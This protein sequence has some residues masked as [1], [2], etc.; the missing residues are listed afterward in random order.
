MFG[1]YRRGDANDP[2]TY[3]ASV[4]AV[5]SGYPPETIKYVT[6]PRTGMASNP[7]RDPKTGQ[8]W[9]GLPDVADV[10]L[11]CEAHYGPT[12]RAIE[13]EA[14][15]HRQ[16][17][18]RKMLAIPDGRPKPTYEE[19]QRRCADAGLMIGPKS[20]RFQPIA[21]EAFCEGYGISKE[22]FDAIPDAK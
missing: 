14:A 12:R 9:T 11:A 1:Q 18:E 10:K 19:L 13:R 15:E 16:L 21:P 6:D 22:Q 5:L 4:A 20:H 2:D 3:V 8:T 7:K 17:A